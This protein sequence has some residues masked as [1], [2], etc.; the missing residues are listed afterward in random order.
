M[1]KRITL[2]MSGLTLTALLASPLTN[3]AA[4]T[5]QAASTAQQTSSQKVALNIFKSNTQQPSE[6]AMFLGKAAQVNLQNGKVTSLTIHVDGSQNKMSQGQ[7]MTK[8]ISSLTINGVPGKVENVAA[9]HSS[10]DFVFGPQAY[11]AGKGK[12]AVSL[13]VM[14]RTM[15]ENADIVLGKL[16]GTKTPAKSY[17]LKHNAYLY[18]A[19]G[20]RVGKK[21]LKAGKKIK[22]SG[23]K[24]INGQLFCQLSHKRF[25]KAGNVL[26]NKRTLKKNAYV[27]RHNGK[28]THKL[29]KKGKQVTIYGSAIKLHGKNFYHISATRF[30]RKANF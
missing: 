16:T 18:N 15:N 10:F 30:V 9:D 25:V 3:V 13:Q 24:T 20:K 19:Q 12:L 27:Y 7:D 5:D 6:A 4:E 21:V 1:N 2:L 11:Q 14:G 8:L 17:T 23:T 28:R 29:L 26:G 22:A